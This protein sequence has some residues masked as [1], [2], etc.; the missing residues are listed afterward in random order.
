MSGTLAGEPTAVTGDAQAAATTVTPEPRGT[1]PGAPG[2]P[3]TFAAGDKD[4]VLTALGSSRVWATVG[5][6]VL[7]EVFWPTTGRPQLRDLGFL[8][9]GSGW[10]T[11]VKR[12]AS[13]T[14]ETPAPD[15]PSPTIV[16]HDPRFRLT[17]RL[18]CDPCRDV[19]A[20]D[21]RLDDVGPEPDPALALHVLVAPHLGGTGRHNTARATAEALLAEREAEAL[22]VVAD[23]GFTLTSAGFV[24]ASDGWHDTDLH[25]HPTWSHAVAPD[26]N[27]ALT[28]TLARPAGTL[29]VGFATTQLGALGLARASLVEGFDTLAEAYESGWRRWAAGITLP[30]GPPELAALARRSA[31]VL[32]AHE[33][34]TFPGAIV[35]SLATPW[36]FAH[37]DPGGYHLVWPRDCAETGLALAALGL[38]PDALRMLELLAA[39]QSPDGHW[40]QNFTP[41]GEPYWTGV[42][43]DETALPVV[44]AAKLDELGVLPPA[45]R[46]RLRV[47]VQRACRHIVATGPLSPQDRWEE[48]AG[49]NP[50]TLAAVIAALVGAGSGGWLAADEA[51]YV[52]SL[53]C[54]WNERVE[55]LLYVVESPLDQRMGTPGHYVRIA[56]GRAVDPR[57]GPSGRLMLA[58]RDGEELDISEVVGLEFLALVRYGLRAPDDPRIR[59]T[60]SIVD[61]TLRGPDAIGPLY[62]RYPHDGYGE[63]P[64]GSPFD[65]SGIGRLWPLLAGERAMYAVAAGEAPEPYL[66]AMARSVTA[67]GM[68]PEQVWDTYPVPERRLYPGR[69]TGSAAP[70]VWAHAELVKVYLAAYGGA[71]PDTLDS[72]VR[73]LGG[74]P[75]PAPTAHLRDETG[76]VVVPAGDLL[77]ESDRPFTLHWGHDGWHD[78]SEV[79]SA[80]LPFDRHG[81]RLVR[82]SLPAGAATVEWT[83][84]HADG[85]EGVDHQVLLTTPGP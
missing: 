35:A 71:R 58:N 7:N 1:A 13:Y 20:V 49:A 30:P 70:L 9:T 83:R 51:A 76:A 10:W 75:P 80:P 82:A 62:W 14:V 66:E 74:T 81:A 25:G 19:V 22:A 21:Y 18:V 23:G 42:Q 79:P 57:H 61:R 44:L 16:H 78:V 34:L 39:L 69:P 85:W 26:G 46:A 64:D 68:L 47:T 8:V 43:L 3:P 29:A 12:A 17:L 6:G 53:A 67:G 41:E 54:W 77:V 37:D 32:R 38:V 2:I 4:L 33:D 45:L 52:R 84:H 65:G 63:N 56:D 50:F 55:P 5:G 15:V 73:L 40:P 11:E 36:G 48:S 60:V 59:H 31:M 28:G 72:V 24:G 27:V